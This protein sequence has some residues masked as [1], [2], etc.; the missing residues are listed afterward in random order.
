MRIDYVRS[1]VA[2]AQEG[3]FTKASKRLH[4][5]QP[6][7]T[8]QIAK[9]EDAIGARLFDRSTRSVELT[10]SGRILL[11][12]AVDALDALDRAILEIHSADRNSQCTLT[13]GYVYQYLSYP[14]TEWVDDFQ[15]EHPEIKVRTIEDSF[16]E[17]LESLSSGSADVAIMGTTDISFIPESFE[18]LYMGETYEELLVWRGHPLAEKGWA[19][20]D[21]IADERLVYPYINPKPEF[22]PLHRDIV[23]HGLEIE[24]IRSG[25]ES[26]GFEAVAARQ[27][28]MG[29]P[30]S[31]K[32]GHEDLVCIPYRSRY[33]IK[34]F[35]LWNGSNRKEALR[36][37][38][39]HVEKRIG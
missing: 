15:K 11:P 37:L 25:F 10:R 29:L 8:R 34:R 28:I 22:S 27:G 32:G 5:A 2:V 6:A 23:E 31:R 38:L 1:F 4:V 16:D 30:S 33:V 21:D 36:S 19:C 20:I 12:A 18:R 13:I 9:L 26:G 7:L 39:A 14:T 35:L 24:F 17:L 3:N